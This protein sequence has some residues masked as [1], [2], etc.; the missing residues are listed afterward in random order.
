MRLR[1]LG[2]TGRALVTRELASGQLQRHPEQAWKDHLV[3]IDANLDLDEFDQAIDRLLATTTEHSS[4]IDRLAAVA[5]HRSLRL[6]R[7]QAVD[8]AIWRF[9]TVVHR[10]EFVRHRWEFLSWPTMRDRF[11]RAGSR[12]DSNAF[13][14]LWWI[15]ELTAIDGDYSL[16]ERA[17]SSQTVAIGVFVRSFGYYRPAAVACIEALEGQPTWV[18]E[19][20]LR[21][22]NAYLSTIVL[23]SRTAAQ[24]RERLEELVDE[25]WSEPVDEA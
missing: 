17:L 3:D 22:F 1:G 15:A 6:T 16:T 2:P 7:R 21:R 19:T 8:A 10:P 11:W 13:S 20:C 25:S 12:H 14:R 23:E 24:L 5:V 4:A 9:L 18:V